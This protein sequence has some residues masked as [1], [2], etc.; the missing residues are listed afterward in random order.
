MP[1]RDDAIVCWFARAF[2]CLC[3]CLVVDVFVRCNVLLFVRMF[4]CVVA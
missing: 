3:V 1:V 2:C 4:I